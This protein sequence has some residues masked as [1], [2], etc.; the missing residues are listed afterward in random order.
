[1]A[2]ALAVLI[3]AAALCN[4]VTN[5]VVIA[6]SDAE[7]RISDRG[8]GLGLEVV[9][10]GAAE[11]KLE[12]R[13]G[14]RF[15]DG[16]TSV[17]LNKAAGK[18]VKS[19]NAVGEGQ[20]AEGSATIVIEDGEDDE[21]GD[22][23]GSVDHVKPI[24]SLTASAPKV[25]AYS[26]LDGGT[27]VSISL[28]ATVTTKGKHRKLDA[29]GN[30]VEE[31]EFLPKRYVWKM[32]GAATGEAETDSS[33]H[34]FV[35]SLTKGKDKKLNFSVVGKIC[36]ICDGE[37]ESDKATDSV[38][39]DVYELSISRPDYLGLDRTDAGRQGHVVKTATLSS[40]PSLPSSS[41]V[42]WT[43]CGIC[44]FVGAKNQR[45]VS[46]QN[47]DSETAS[48]SYLAER[49]AA[50]V[51][52]AGMD[53]S[54]VC[55]TNFTVVKVDVVLSDLEEP[56]EE[57][58]GAILSFMSEEVP[59][60][61]QN[62][63]ESIVPVEVSYCPKNLP[64]DVSIMIKAPSKTL[65]E[66]SGDKYMLIGGSKSYNLAEF[67][68][69]SFILCGGVESNS[70]CDQELVVQIVSANAVDRCCITAI[71]YFFAGFVDQPANGKVWDF[72]GLTIDVGH[73]FWSLECSNRGL[74]PGIANDAP[75]NRQVGFYSDGMHNPD[76]THTPD[77]THRWPVSRQSFA[78]SL[79][80]TIA[81]IDNPPVYSLKTNNCCNLMVN[82]ANECGIWIERTIE[83][84]PLGK[85]MTPHALGN[86]ITNGNWHYE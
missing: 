6:T 16:S 71:A 55:S 56:R 80:F 26:I 63:Q 41:S 61:A 70:K 42:E 51:R 40:D 2:L 58:N 13:P 68:S 85:S 22:D 69:R 73:A 52:L 27:N 64:R 4:T 21:D 86:D 20:S 9:G 81:Q 43:E 79:A 54:V 76:T 67:T 75:V 37:V 11:V 17:T 57:T 48:G 49:L 36:G 30:V 46:Y 14:W 28:S 32:T 53:S 8:L 60:M 29:E 82:A 39:I 50:S 31:T 19:P 83:A 18:S 3:G 47:K 38:E 7:L 12:T 66:K 45:S 62:W 77:V 59:H 33:T 65:F 1:M 72:V 15:R 23:E 74:D 35:A 10:G 25:V 78:R 5:D 84:W 34:T 24:L 44:E